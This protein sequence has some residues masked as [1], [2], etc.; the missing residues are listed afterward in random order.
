MDADSSRTAAAQSL[1]PMQTRPPQVSD[2]AF[3]LFH[4]IDR[5]LFA[6]LTHP[7]A[8]DPA[9]SVRVAAFFIWL[10]RESHD[11]SLVSRLL[12]LPPAILNA[13]A[14]EAALCLR[15]AESD[16]FPPAA[17]GNVTLLPEILSGGGISLRLIQENRAAVLRAVAKIV[18]TV[19][20]RAFADILPPP[21]PAAAAAAAVLY[22]PH[23]NMPLMGGG[24]LPV[25]PPPP[26]AGVFPAPGDIM[27]LPLH[28]MG[29]FPAHDFLGRNVAVNYNN[30]NDESEENGGDGGGESQF[31][32][33]ADERTIFL[34][35]SKGYPISEDEVK[36][37]FT[38]MF[39]DFIEDL[40]MQEVCEDEQV[41]YARMVARSTA[42]IDGIVGGNKAKYVINGKHVWA[43]KYV[44]KHH[45]QAR[46]PP[47]RGGDDHPSSSSS[48]S[49]STVLDG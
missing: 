10:E 48:P 15:C 14:A 20:L 16:S 42:V 35:F 7:L 3:N 13:A 19:C 40:I 30:G 1:F 44:K 22:R 23:P 37:Y 6:R 4:S 12:S 47:A 9:E 2:E 38:R 29:N 46:W 11:T 45:H 24:L 39:G 43:R 26:P 5:E 34:T 31:E 32:V 33:A 17:A 36:E 41:L 49:S 8:R 18:S 25:S 27:G 28:M 21:P